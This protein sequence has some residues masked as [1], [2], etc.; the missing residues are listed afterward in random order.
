MALIIKLRFRISFFAIPAFCRK[1]FYHRG[2]KDLHKG[3]EAK[4]KRQFFFASLATSLPPF[5]A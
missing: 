3:H 2:H 5:F 4:A 1:I